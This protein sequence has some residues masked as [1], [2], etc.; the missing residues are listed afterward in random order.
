IMGEREMESLQPAG[1]RDLPEIGKT[2]RD[3]SSHHPVLRDVVV[4]CLDV[5]PD[6][7]YIDGTLGL[8][9]HA[10][11]ILRKLSPRGRLLGLDVDPASLAAAKDRLQP[12]EDQ[13]ITRLVS[14]RG[15]QGVLQEVGWSEVDGMICDL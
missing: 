10:E 1:R 3:L 7:L 11:A 13:T 5:K 14:F 15:L 2:F 8:G 12:F 9:G 4:D 6:G